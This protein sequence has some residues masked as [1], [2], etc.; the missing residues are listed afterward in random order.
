MIL[1]KDMLRNKPPEVWTVEPEAT[2]YEALEVMSDK[3]IGAVP[4][5]QDGRVV[6]MF[7]ERDYARKVILHGRSSRDT[8]VRELMSSPVFTVECNETI[9]T[10][11]ALMSENRLRH[12]PVL[13]DSRMVGLVSIGDVLKAIITEQQTQIKDLGDYIVGKPVNSYPPVGSLDRL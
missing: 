3:D 10:C 9:E 4:V 6:G 12:L 2:V 13:E 8:T 11:M 1:V 5:V 7:S